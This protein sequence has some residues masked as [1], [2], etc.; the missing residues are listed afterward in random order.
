MPFFWFLFY[1]TDWH[2]YEYIL[3]T[4][5]LLGGCMGVWTWSGLEACLFWSC[6]NVIVVRVKVSWGIVP[7]PQWR[8]TMR[9]LLE[10]ETNRE[11]IF[12]GDFFWISLRHSINVAHFFL[13]SHC[14][15][16]FFWPNS[17]PIFIQYTSYCIYIFF[18]S[19]QC[20]VN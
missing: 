11:I 2:W 9:K 1:F 13:V 3:H 14:F 4:V 5:R 17:C 19:Q 10:Q 20:S 7:F 6:F 8:S 15:A 16:H 12:A 18:D